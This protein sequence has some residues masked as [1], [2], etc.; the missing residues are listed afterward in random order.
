METLVIF[1][2][3]ANSVNS[4]ANPKLR[5]VGSGSGTSAGSGSV[6]EGSGTRSG[7]G[8]GQFYGGS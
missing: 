8:F 5:G 4:T 3:K 6:S 7:S 1:T 2:A